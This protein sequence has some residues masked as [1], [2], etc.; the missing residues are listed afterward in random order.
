MGA[1]GHWHRASRIKLNG[2]RKAHQDSLIRAGRLKIYTPE[3]VED[4]AQSRGES[5]ARRKVLRRSYQR[6]K[7]LEEVRD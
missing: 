5:A 4:F 3:E 6:S 7:K 1:A 2:V